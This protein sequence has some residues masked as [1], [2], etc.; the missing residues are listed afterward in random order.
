M[1]IQRE[2]REQ[3]AAAILPR[4]ANFWKQGRLVK[5]TGKMLKVLKVNRICTQHKMWTVMIGLKFEDF[6]GP[7][8]SLSILLQI[9]CA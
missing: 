2:R 3:A 9:I 4:L 7:K 6:M 5:A 8:L 1:T